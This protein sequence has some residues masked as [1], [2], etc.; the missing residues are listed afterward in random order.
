[1]K[2]FCGFWLHLQSK[3]CKGA[4]ELVLSKGCYIFELFHYCQ[5]QGNIV[6]HAFLWF[7]FLHIEILVELKRE[8]RR[9][10]NALYMAKLSG[11]AA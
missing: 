4:Q 11:P 2:F 8:P 9:G 1:M 10:T 3:F 6:I 7:I 5:G